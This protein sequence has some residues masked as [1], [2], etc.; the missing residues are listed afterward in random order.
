MGTRGWFRLHS[1][2]GVIT[3]LLLFVVCWSGTFATIAHELDW[4]VTPALRVDRGER[5][6]GWDA[7]D[8]AA[9]GAVPDAEPGSIAAPLNAHAASV[10][11]MEQADGGV[12]LVAVDPYTGRATGVLEG[13]YTI[14]RFFRSFHMALF[15]PTVGKYVVTLLSLTML[16]SMVAA[17][18][19]YKR[20]WT[21]FFRFRPGKGRA[22]WS[23]LHKTGGLWSLWF[24]LVLGLTGAWYLFEAARSDFGDGKVNYAGSDSTYALK[25]VP[26]PASDP[27]RPRLGLDALVARAQARWPDFQP[28]LLAANWSSGDA[29][30]IEGQTGFPLVRGRANQ[31]NLDPR[32]GEVLLAH[33]ADEL[34]AYWIWSNMADPLH[35]G[36]FAGLPTKLVWF[37]FGL[38]LSGLV[39]TGTLLHA[40]RL[41]AQGA[42]ADRHRWA[43]TGP[44]LV[45][46]MLVL[47]ASVPYGLHEAREYYGPTVGGVRQ[48]PT[49]M[50]G[51]KLVVGGWILVTL[52]LLAA[53]VRLLQA[54]P[55]AGADAAPPVGVQA[56][57]PGDAAPTRGRRRGA[58][59]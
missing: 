4:L 56:A 18:F 20:W 41:A 36:D 34:S 9:R 33:R 5:T 12:K 13:R 50:A 22:F 38:L 15:L 30:Y 6:V 48:L 2:T 11:T 16:L 29:V 59:A 47:A 31:L 51:A 14:Q 23:E 55:A 49:M 37:V 21:R 58:A 10:V 3:G 39:F 19:V 28:T 46:S 27:S 54:R 44:A 7:I 52:G 17:L 26:A 35:F 8:A 1:F 43:G 40:R 24:V 45:V 32:T 53:W 57:G 25:V 42:S